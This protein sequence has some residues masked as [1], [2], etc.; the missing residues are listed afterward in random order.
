MTAPL[1]D[2]AGLTELLAA[3]HEALSVPHAS[4]A[5]G[6]AVRDA[7]VVQRAGHAMIALSGVLDGDGAPPLW[8][9][10]WLRE[11][12]AALPA[13]GYARAGQAGHLHAV[14]GPDMPA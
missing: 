12:T 5:G 4:T 10:A 14:P 6:Q 1:D 3:V 2:A 8:W 7:I 11:H 9:A 13:D